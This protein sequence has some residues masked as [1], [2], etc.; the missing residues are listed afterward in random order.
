MENKKI[1][2]F[3]NLVLPAPRKHDGKTGGLVRLI[4]VMKRF[5]ADPDKINVQINCTG[6]VAGYF[7]DSGLEVKYRIIKSSLTFYGNLE[8][9]LKALFLMIR[10]IS[11]FIIPKTKNNDEKNVVYCSSDLFWEV[12]LAY[13]AKFKNKD[14]EWVQVIHHIYPSW[15]ARSGSVVTNFFGEYFQ[16]FSFFLICRKAD[17][18]I[19]V[20]PLIKDSLIKNGFRKEKIYVLSNGVDVEYFDRIIKEEPSYD[21]VFLGRLS[22]SKGI[23]DLIEIWKNV[24]EKL[25]EARLAIIGGGEELTKDDLRKIIKENNLEKNIQLLG[26]VEDEQAYRILKSGKIFISPSHE[27]G[28]GIAIAEALACGLPAISW[29]LVNYKPVFEDYT[30]QIRENNTELFSDKIIETLK[31][32]NRRQ[33]LGERGKNFIKKYSWDN[34]AREELNIINS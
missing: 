11:V 28:W 5:S 19:L 29:D 22:V 4:Q 2:I 6:Q 27:E 31:D 10:H 8:L 13:I 24:V 34:V 7:R 32:E 21:G 25:P 26:F 16:K 12:I 33:E 15:R 3:I 14:V 17:K 20:N 23:D 30:I 1:N 9:C 18:I